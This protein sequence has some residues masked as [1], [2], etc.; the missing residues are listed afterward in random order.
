MN[1]SLAPV[2]VRG[3]EAT[4]DEGEEVE[5]DEDEDDE[6]FLEIEES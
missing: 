3:E 4:T 2:P 1:N 5:T 6:D